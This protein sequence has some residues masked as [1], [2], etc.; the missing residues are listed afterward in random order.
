MNKTYILATMA[1][2]LLGSSAAIAGSGEYRNTDAMWLAR[3]KGVNTS[4]DING[5]IGGK[6]YCFGDEKSKVEFMK[7]PE[8]NRTKA[9]AYY[10]TKVNDPNWVPCDYSSDSSY[11]G[12]E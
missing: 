10:A 1:G 2:L 5:T 3:G 7:D 6:T 4:C 8:G 12:C 11:N 9:D